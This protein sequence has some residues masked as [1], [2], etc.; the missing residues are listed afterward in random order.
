M[1]RLSSGGLLAFLRISLGAIFVI[2]GLK[3]AFPPDPA[4][5][6][7]SFVD[8]AKGFISPFFVGWI[9]ETLGLQIGAF[10]RIQG[11]LEISL[12]LLVMLGALVPI[13]GTI[14]GLMLWSFTVAGPDAGAIRLSGD[15]ALMG[16][17]FAV[18]LA[19]AGGW[20][21]DSQPG[22]FKTR[23][24]EVRD[25]FFVAIRLS[26][27]YAL[28][29]SSL[30]S[31]GVF[32]NHLNATLPAPV[33]FFLGA[34]LAVGVFPRWGMFVLFLW[35]LCLVPASVVEK[36]IYFG[37]DSAKREIGF[38]AASFVYILAGPDR[39][40]WLKAGRV[41]FVSFRGMGVGPPAGAYRVSQQ[42]ANGR[43]K[44]Y[45]QEISRRILF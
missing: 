38:L 11:F 20:S 21:A 39:W 27:A 40:A 10:L 44:F 28:L 42:A 5:L 30:F 34:I 45:G 9:T 35:A 29:V 1:F 43:E 16:C 25:F 2:G 22:L 23:Y 24:E 36:G 15:I 32:N 33:L 8:P 14:M 26:L 6:V 3:L 31:G 37:L 41:P 19:G 7:V 12:G 13:A 4:A 18:A 17:S